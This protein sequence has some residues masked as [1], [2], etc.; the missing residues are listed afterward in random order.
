[1]YRQLLFAIAVSV[2]TVS[3]AL[4]VL[5]D[6]SGSPGGPVS[7]RATVQALKSALTA[8]DKEQWDKVGRIQDPIAQAVSDW[9]RLRAEQGSFEEYV[10]FADRYAEWP[11]IPLLRQRGESSIT[12]STPDRAV[13]S[14][15]VAQEP[16]T[17]EGALKYA[18]ALRNVGRV[19]D[20][21]RQLIEAWK[22]LPME[23]STQA[24]YLGRYSRLLSPYHDDRL[25]MLLWRSRF[26]EA[27]RMFPLV[28][29]G[30][31]ALAKARIAL[32][33]REDGVDA[34]ISAVPAARRD[35]PG[36]AYERFVWRMRKDRDKDAAQLI[37]A[38]SAA[39]N[40]G[41]PE[42]WASRRRSLARQLMNA[43]DYATAY[44]VASDH[45]LTEGV[46]Y[47]DLEWLSGYILLRKLNRPADALQRFINHHDGVV[48]PISLGRAGYWI[49]RSY[50]AMGMTAEA[51]AA[52]T[53]AAAHQSSYYGQLATEKLGLPTDPALLGG[54]RHPDWRGQAFASTDL[55][56]A[57]FLLFEAGEEA[58][59][60]W[61]L[62]TLADSLPDAQLGSLASAA[63]DR[64]AYHLALK[65]AKAAAQRGVILGDSY[66]P[67]TS[68]ARADLPVGKA[69]ALSIARRESEFNIAAGSS[70]G[71]QGLM[72]LMP[73]TAKMMA[74]ELNVDYRPERL[75]TDADYNASLGSAYLAGLIR[76]FGFNIPL[77]AAGYNAG[78]GRPKQWIESM[79]DP[80]E[81]SVDAVD[82]VESV[83]FRET[84][85]YIM[86]VAESIPIYEMRLKGQIEPLRP[87][88]LLKGR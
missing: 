8:I 47:A 9:S 13:I 45:G 79:G 34:L 14:Y 63:M 23:E 29:G 55:F 50:E 54:D 51:T 88:A 53:E 28:S 59:G 26:S 75:M 57:A 49:G 31:L 1:M 7:D 85:N 43:G 71:A 24:L 64:Q 78:P 42:Q 82:W 12:D 44:L 77:V 40:L 5:A 17:A 67:V 32:R 76:Q 30:D 25:D 60:A 4:P 52:Y 80:R 16:R 20:A 19:S 2:G 18:E 38:Q 3:A 73:G 87:T 21:D 58:T 62:G 11:G 84:R 35:D 56:K 69:L 36:L 70:A 68:L 27:E 39:K 72:Q 61:F 22:T 46:D 65:V 86:R 41:D 37:I 74:R 10:R 15:F 6:P 33:R 81:P 66:F 48:S 83:P